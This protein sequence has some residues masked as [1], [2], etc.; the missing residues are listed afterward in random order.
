MSQPPGSSKPKSALPDDFEEIEF[1]V[2]EENWNEYELNDGNRLMARIIL[3]K[4][5]R[6][7]NDPKQLSFDTTTP[8]YSVYSPT[9]N[10]GERN[11]P[12]Q[13]SEYANFESYETKITRSDERWNVYTILRSGQKLRLRL[14][15]TLIRRVKDRF[16]KDGMPFYL[17][18]SG[19]M[20]LLDPIKPKTGQ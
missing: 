16:D 19:P 1:S 11:N 8:I 10:R 6:D 18:N 20:I 3:K 13:P 15:V 5:V 17:V 2:E 9:A 4:I 12:P 14:T 7:P